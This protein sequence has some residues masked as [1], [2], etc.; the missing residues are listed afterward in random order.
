MVARLLVVCVAL[1]LCA[2]TTRADANNTTH[3]SMWSKDQHQVANVCILGEF[4]A[5]LAFARE[6]LTSAGFK[7]VE[8]CSA[9]I[10]S[11]TMLTV[12]RVKHPDGTFI[13]RVVIDRVEDEGM[14][15]VFDRKSSGSFRAGE[16]HEDAVRRV[17]CRDRG[18]YMLRLKELKQ[19]FQDEYH[20]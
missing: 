3:S 18:T 11:D 17:L 15:R 20:W 13:I 16:S 12:V 5:D 7:D 19:K 6:L 4:R 14:V 8:L 2:C 1:L 10:E 9:E